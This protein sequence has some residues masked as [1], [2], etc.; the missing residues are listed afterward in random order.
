MTV[1]AAEAIRRVA[2]VGAGTMG[3]GIAQVAAL[4]GCEVKLATRCRRPAPPSQGQ[5]LARDDGG[6]E[7]EGPPSDGGGLVQL[8]EA[9]RWRMP[10][11]H[12]PT[13]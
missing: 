1:V 10:S 2:V 6:G 8:M 7:R 4:A 3:H 13:W 12:E 5:S 9:Q 11:P